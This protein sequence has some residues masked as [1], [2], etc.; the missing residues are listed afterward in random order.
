MKFNE[1]NAMKFTYSEKKK[2]FYER[3]DHLTQT[4]LSESSSDAAAG[5]EHNPADHYCL[6]LCV[7]L[8]A[9]VTSRSG[10]CQ[11]LHLIYYQQ[12]SKQT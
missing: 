9:R 3:S 12:Q 7:F 6:I 11:V 10:Q 5:S 1:M 8:T 2:T 4:A